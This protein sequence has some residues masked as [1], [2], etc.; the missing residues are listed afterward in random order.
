L[1]LTGLGLGNVMGYC[2]YGNEPLG[3]TRRRISRRLL[4]ILIEES[5]H[6]FFAF[7]RGISKLRPRIDA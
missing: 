1:D 5:F 2:Q 6:G 7:Y 4:A 3:F